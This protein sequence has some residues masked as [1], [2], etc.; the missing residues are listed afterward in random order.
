[1]EKKESATVSLKLLLEGIGSSLSKGEPVDYNSLA[2]RFINYFYSEPQVCPKPE[3]MMI[4]EKAQYCTY[5]FC[6]HKINHLPDSYCLLSHCSEFPEEVECKPI[7]ACIPVPSTPTKCKKCGS[8][9]GI[10]HNGYCY[11]CWNNRVASTPASEVDTDF[12]NPYKAGT[13]EHDEWDE[14]ERVGKVSP[15]EPVK[16][17]EGLL[18][19]DEEIKIAL[20]YKMGAILLMDYGKV[21]KAQLLKCHKSE[22]AKIKQLE[23]GKKLSMES[24]NR[25]EQAIGKV[26]GYPAYKNDQKNFPN[27]TEANGVCVG[28][29]VAESLVMELVGRFKELEAD[30]EE[31]KILNQNNDKAIR[32]DQN[33]KIGDA[34]DKTENPYKSKGV[35]GGEYHGTD[36]GVFEIARQSFKEVITKLQ[37]GETLSK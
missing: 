20:G 2:E 5:A 9:K 11:D 33:K 7:P 10:Y 22:A 4:C 25:I 30:I 21:A 26:L 8:I 23:L 13:Q 29:H 36:Y 6:P 31:L 18:L 17:D 35:F 34:I 27:A 19:T 12:T 16:P 28:D 37:N 3:Q 24:D 1:M 15:P 32:A 14:S